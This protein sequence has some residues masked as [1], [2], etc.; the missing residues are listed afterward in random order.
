MAAL[1]AWGRRQPWSRIVPG[2]VLLSAALL[3]PAHATDRPAFPG[4]PLMV[5]L[6]QAT[7]LKLPERTATL[8]VGNPLVADVSVQ[9]GGTVVA[10]GKGYGVT[11]LLALDR[12]GSVTMERAITVQGPSDTVMV[13]YRGVDR[14]TY[15]C[16]PKCER[17][18]MLGD[19]QPYFAATIAQTGT[20]NQQAQGQ[21]QGSAAR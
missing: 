15:S 14:E 19:A 2:A 21:S 10:T 11:N 20:L 4:V 3:L 13:V 12:N 17:R 6:D 16:T 9:P 18:I 8:V 5:T 1:S 7:V